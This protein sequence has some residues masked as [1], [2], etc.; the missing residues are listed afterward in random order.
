MIRGLQK[1]NSIKVS[2]S[3][4]ETVFGKP[5]KVSA[6]AEDVIP[7]CNIIILP[8][9]SLTYESILWVYM[10]EFNGLNYRTFYKFGH[11][12]KP[13]IYAEFLIDM[14]KMIFYCFL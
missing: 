6:R 1:N 5:V 8:V 12:L 10:K 7:D 9:R 2:L 11:E 13:A 3:D 14:V 4:N